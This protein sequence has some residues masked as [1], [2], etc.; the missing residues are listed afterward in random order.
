MISFW[1]REE[2]YFGN[3]GARCKKICDILT[4]NGIRF[5]TRCKQTTHG[6][7]FGRTRRSKPTGESEYD[8]TKQYYIY[9]HKD[10]REAAD[11]LIRRSE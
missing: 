4:R 1:N 3:S 6:Y 9:V 5:I 2:V 10:D 11:F 7:P 8:W